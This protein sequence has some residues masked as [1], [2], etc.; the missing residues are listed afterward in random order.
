MR[1]VR[2]QHI[3][4]VL[5]TCLGLAAPAVAAGQARPARERYPTAHCYD[6]TYYYGK[7][8][9]KACAHHRGVAE[10]LAPPPR[11]PPPR[12]SRAVPRRR[13]ARPPAGATARCKD[14]TYSFT[15]RRAAACVHHGGIARWLRAR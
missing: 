13:S 3:G 6:G 10:W 15:H 14:G 9:A 2:A 8:H 7:S 12:P 4:L 1:M 5:A 11:T